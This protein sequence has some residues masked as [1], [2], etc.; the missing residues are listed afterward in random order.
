[1]KR[2]EEGTITI[3]YPWV[4]GDPHTI[5]LITENGI[6]TEGEIAAATLTPEPNWNNFLN[7]GFIGF[8]VGIVPIAL[9]LLWYPFMKRFKRKWINALLALTVGL[10]LFLFVGTLADGFEIGAEAP[11]VFQ[12]NMVVIIGATLTFLLL[13]GFDQYQQIK[14]NAKGHSP[15]RLALLMA[16]G[17]GLHNFGEGLAIGSSFALGEAALGTFLIIGFTLHNITEGIGIAAPLLK[18]KP[19]LKDFFVL[20]TV[21]GAPAILGTWFGGF[22]F[23]P[24]WGALFLGIGAGA[25]LQ[26]IFVITKMLIEDHKKYNEPSISWIDFSSFAIGLLIMY[27]TAFFVKY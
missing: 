27:F 10:L 19:K 7:Y 23:S 1:M 21:A 11:A 20:G 24:I 4:E 12:G 18:T 25:I 9:G 3:P 26:V 15:F 22:I 13:V 14:Q 8:Y 16:T 17:I 5:K 6:I 2:F